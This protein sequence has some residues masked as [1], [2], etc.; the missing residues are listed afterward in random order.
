[1][2]IVVR[3]LELQTIHPRSFTITEKAPTKTFFFLLKA[4][5]YQLFHILDTIKKL[6]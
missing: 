6:R 4:T 2:G 3:K 5:T 1:M